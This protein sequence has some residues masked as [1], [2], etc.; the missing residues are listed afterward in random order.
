MGINVFPRSLL[1]YRSSKHCLTRD[2]IA[3]LQQRVGCDLHVRL[4]RGKLTMSNEAN[5][6][7]GWAGQVYV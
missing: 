1:P 5:D 2:T 4:S 7:V 6:S 3:Q